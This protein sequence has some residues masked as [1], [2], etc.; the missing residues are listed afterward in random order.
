MFDGSI[1]RSQ[2]LFADYL[3]AQVEAGRLK[4][5]DVDLAAAQLI[6]LLKTNIHMKLVL[7]RPVRIGPKLID[8]SARASIALFLH[9]AMPDR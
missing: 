2:R 4:L 9:G 7:G 5:D 6:A 3:R 1:M 8:A